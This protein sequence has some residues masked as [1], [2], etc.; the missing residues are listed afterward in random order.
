MLAAAAAGLLVGGLLSAGVAQAA[1]PTDIGKDKGRSMK[2]GH[3]P[4][5]PLPIAKKQAALKK[6]ALERRLKGD[7]AMQGKVA[8]VGKGQYVELQREATDP[9]FVIL[10]EFGDE[11]YPNPIFQG[12]PPDGSTTDVTGPLH[13]QIPEPNRSSTTPRCGRRTTTS[14]TTTTCTSTGWRRTSR[15]S[16]PTATRSRAR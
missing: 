11:Q 13:N 6:S 10:V 12:P 1:P 2:G 16:R 8:K 3:V 15:R 5:H 4:E 14:R 9:V 7:K